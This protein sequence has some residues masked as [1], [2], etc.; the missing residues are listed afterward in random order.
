MCYSA[1]V[2][3]SPWDYK[4]AF[5]AT[6]D[7]EAFARLYQ[8]QGRGGAVKTAKGMDDV[9]MAGSAPDEVEIKAHI[10]ARNRNRLQ[11]FEQQLFTQA[12]RLANVERKLAVK[13]TLTGE[14]EQRAASNKIAQIKR[15][16]ADMKR[17]DPVPERDNRIWPNSFCPVMLVEDGRRV[18]RP[19]RYHLRPYWM[20]ASSDRTK[21]GKTSGKYNARRDRLTGFWRPLFGV[22]HAVVVATTFYENV[23]GED[24]QSKVLAFTPRT[25][26]PMLIACLWSPWSDSAGSEPDLLS[27]AAITDEPEPEVAQA[28]HDRTIINLKPEHIDAWLNPDAHDAVYLQA[29][30]DDKRHPYYENR[31]AA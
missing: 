18:I 6:P 27:F 20:P 12:A 5:G 17:G 23:T 11:A 31:A 28:G 30:L 3:P 19:M 10:Q 25:C 29:I 4:K 21:D 2:W 7:L 1:E 24:G 9:F 26:E 14:K 15:W 13:P 22:R 16:I 8:L